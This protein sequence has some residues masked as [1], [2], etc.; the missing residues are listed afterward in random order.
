[1]AKLDDNVAENKVVPEKT[2]VFDEL[3]GNFVGCFNE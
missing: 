2:A 1:M 3:G